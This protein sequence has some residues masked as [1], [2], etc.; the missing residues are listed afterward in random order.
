MSLV[1]MLPVIVVIATMLAQVPFLVQLG[2]SALP[3]SILLGMILGHIKRAAPGHSELKFVN[4]CRRQLLR[5]GIILFGFHLNF[6]QIVA[7]GWQALLIDILIILSI[8][9]IGTFVG[10]RIL[11]LSTSVSIL[12]SVGSAICGA[13]AVM[14]TESVLKSDQR[15]VSIAV[16]TVVLFGTLAMFS[17]PIIYQFTDMDEYVFGIYIGS[18]VHEIAQAAAAGEAIGDEAL[19]NAVIVKLIRVMLLAPFLIILFSLLSSDNRI[20]KNNYQQIIPW[21]IL[22][23]IGAAGINSFILL[24]DWLLQLLDFTSQFMLGIAMA[25][26]GTQ[27]HWTTIQAAGLRPIVLS[28]ILFVLLL[29]GGLHINKSIIGVVG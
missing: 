8:F 16:A 7:L 2:V 18:T 26:L 29:V 13:A 15:Y 19:K 22:G 5:Y 9:V 4:Y 20:G 24:P 17:Y 3:L 11:K 25:A 10:V 12:I 28:F 6:H 23:F 21:F 14:A 1:I 27:T